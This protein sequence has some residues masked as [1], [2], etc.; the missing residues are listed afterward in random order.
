MP[1]VAAES[2]PLLKITTSLIAHGCIFISGFSVEYSAVQPPVGLRPTGCIKDAPP[3]RPLIVPLCLILC[4]C[5]RAGR[6]EGRAAKVGSA[7]TS[8]QRRG[9]I[10]NLSHHFVDAQPCR[11]QLELESAEGEKRSGCARLL[12]R[13]N[14]GALALASISQVQFRTHPRAPQRR[15]RLN[16]TVKALRSLQVGCFSKR[17]HPKSNLML[18][19]VAFRLAP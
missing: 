13:D 3:P 10:N 2:Q 5:G 12:E 14:G 8:L 15:S 7:F 11:N 6:T 4:L 1:E 19:F 16:G 17:E 9:T 18:Y